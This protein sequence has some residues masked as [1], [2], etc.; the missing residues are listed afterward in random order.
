M[1][2]PL[3]QFVQL[4][5]RIGRA[6]PA[7]NQGRGGN[8]SEKWADSDGKE[9]IRIKA[10][11]YRLSQVTQESGISQIDLTATRNH[12]AALRQTALDKVEAEY[13]AMLNRASQE[14]HCPFQPSMETGFHVVL[15]RRYVIHFHSL[16]AIA[17]ASRR[18]R[19]P[20]FWETWLGTESGTITL[21]RGADVI[22]L[23]MSFLPPIRPGYLLTSPVGACRESDVI[24]LGNHGIILHSETPAI[25]EA[26]ANFEQ[27]FLS[28]I[29]CGGQVREA[30]VPD[31]SGLVEAR[32]IFTSLPLPFKMLYPDFAVFA[33]RVH[34]VICPAPNGANGLYTLANDAFS[35]DSDAAEM[36]LAHGLLCQIAPDLEPLPTDIAAVVG[37]LP[38]EALRKDIARQRA[39]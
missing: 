14:A 15:P 11:G 3:D 29:G 8:V 16:A 12:L 21:S 10:S 1:S 24:V 28:K 36:W 17:L 7:W 13:A 22:P 31:A 20:G 2:L 32:K 38:T 27:S 18:A 9:W 26:W 19:D 35:R 4:C 39:D 23:K 37:E 6:V 25:L 33:D 30:L 34:A 5:H